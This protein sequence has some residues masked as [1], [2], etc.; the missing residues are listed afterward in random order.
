[1]ASLA[2][3]IAK[4]ISPAPSFRDPEDTVDGKKVL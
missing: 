1:M 4:L 3:Q 2:D